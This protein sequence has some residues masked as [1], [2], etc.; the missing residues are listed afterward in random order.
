MTKILQL[1][2]KVRKKTGVGTRT[3][4]H[5]DW[6]APSYYV[7]Y[8]GIYGHSDKLNYAQFYDRP[9]RTSD[10]RTRL[11]H[12][13]RDTDDIYDRGVKLSCIHV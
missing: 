9:L 11:K 1:F 13:T 6:L 2:V 7:T 4:R 8:Y 5:P 10:L 12:N 3:A